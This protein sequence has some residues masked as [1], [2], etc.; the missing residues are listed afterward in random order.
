M[1]IIMLDLGSRTVTN[2]IL[3]VKLALVL[4]SVIPVTDP[5]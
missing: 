3:I 2:V 5:D 1:D 4:C